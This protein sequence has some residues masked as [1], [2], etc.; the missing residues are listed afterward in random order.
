M[1]D[2]L[3]YFVRQVCIRTVKNAPVS[4]A[5]IISISAGEGGVI[6]TYYRLGNPAKLSWPLWDYR[7]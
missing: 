4:T 1:Y 7:Y 3:A 6:V 2:N 5:D